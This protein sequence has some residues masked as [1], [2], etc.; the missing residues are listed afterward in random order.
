MLFR[1]SPEKIKTAR[2]WIDGDAVAGPQRD[3]LQQ[4]GD[5]NQRISLGLATQSEIIDA[6]GITRNTKAQML[7]RFGNVTDDIGAATKSIERAV[8]IF[9]AALPPELPTPQARALAVKTRNENV[10]ALYEYARTPGPDGR[11]PS[12]PEIRAH[13][14]VL[15]D[16]SSKI[17]S[18]AFVVIAPAAESE[19]RMMLP[20]LA[21]VDLLNQ[22]AVEEAI[23]K[24]VKRGATQNSINPALESIKRFREASSKIG[25]AQ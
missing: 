4:L 6:P 16:Q 15:A 13:G 14:N 11:L 23:K 18:S 9:S 5:L 10:A 17:I 20:E 22:A 24:A 8:G 2:S 19:A 7:G 25:A 12:P 3:D 1:S 21:N